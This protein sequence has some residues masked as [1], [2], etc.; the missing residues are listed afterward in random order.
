MLLSKRFLIA[1]TVAVLVAAAVA[2]GAFSYYHGRTGSVYH[3]HARFVPEPTPAPVASATPVSHFLWPIYGYTADHT[4][5]FPAPGNLHPPFTK[6]WSHH[7]DALLEF[8]P[9]IR[10]QRLFQLADNGLLVSINKN[11][12]H[13]MWPCRRPPP[14]STST[15]CTRR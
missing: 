11:T 3:P 6:V 2:I 4:R 14:R 9:V 10:D 13:T 7:G 15:R 5:D 1:A 12:G 8:P